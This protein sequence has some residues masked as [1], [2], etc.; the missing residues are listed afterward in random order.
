MKLTEQI[1]V[2]AETQKVLMKRLAKLEVMQKTDKPNA[3]RKS[4]Y[5]PKIKWTHMPTKAEIHQRIDARFTK[6][7]NTK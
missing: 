4:S 5:V 7:K 1:A 6:K 2:L 3:K